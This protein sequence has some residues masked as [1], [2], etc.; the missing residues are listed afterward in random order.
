LSRFFEDI[1]VGEAMDLGAHTFTR[2]EILS[3]ARRF[4]P[5]HFHVDEEAARDS[6][7]GGLCASGWHTIS[8]WMRLFIREQERIAE[9]LARAGAPA[10]RLGPSPGI[11]ELKWLKPVYPGDVITY[12]TVPEEKIDMPL[13]P[14]W[15]LLHLTAEGVNQAGDPVVSFRGWV[16]VERRGTGGA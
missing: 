3:Y 6:L 16:Y 14:E 9:E 8:V 10:A 12:T 11:R 4:D 7:F 13:Q 15:G 5:Q 1:V 2:E